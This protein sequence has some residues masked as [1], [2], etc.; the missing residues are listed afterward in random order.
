MLVV[1]CGLRLNRLAE[2]ASRGVYSC[3]ARYMS[4]EMR[5]RGREAQNFR[6]WVLSG[7]VIQQ[8]AGRGE[9][10]DERAYVTV[11]EGW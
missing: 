7:T 3:C 6:V 4:G 2:T 5:R 9:A 1:W 11:G 10:S 8:C